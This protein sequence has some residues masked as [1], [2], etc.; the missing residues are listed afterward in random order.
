LSVLTLAEVS[1]SPARYVAQSVTE[2]RLR[3]AASVRLQTQEVM[4]IDAPLPWRASWLTSGPYDDGWLKPG[5]PARIRIFPTSSE[6]APRIQRLTLQI[7]AADGVSGMPFVVTS[8]LERVAGAASGG[9]TAAV[10]SLAVCVP[11]VG[12]ADV[13]VSAR[14]ASTIPGDLSS[15]ETSQQQRQGSIYLADISVS[16]D[17]GPRCS[18]GDQRSLAQG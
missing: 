1:P 12:H 18:L 4:L 5:V 15:L 7:T 9:T 10:N 8:N 16:D 6:R 14:G 11:E 13:V 3:I 2:S 17:L